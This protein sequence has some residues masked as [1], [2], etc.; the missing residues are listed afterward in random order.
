L[1]LKDCSFKKA[2]VLL[3]CLELRKKMQFP[4]FD[5]IDRQKSQ[6]L[7]EAVDDIKAKLP[8]AKLRWA[9]EGLEQSWKTHFKKRSHR[10]TTRWDEL[11][12]V[13]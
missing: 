2:G 5:E 3:S 6:I 8:E 7:M 11:L 9:V 13:G 12:K 4:L 10:Y 1:Y